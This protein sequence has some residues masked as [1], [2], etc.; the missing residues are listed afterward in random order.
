MLLLRLAA[1]GQSA[2]RGSRVSAENPDRPETNKRRNDIV[3]E[4]NGPEKNGR[5]PRVMRTGRRVFAVE[6]VGNLFARS[7]AIIAVGR[8]A[9]GKQ[10]KRVLYCYH[11][12]SLARASRRDL[13]RMT[14]SVSRS[15]AR[16]RRPQRRWRTRIVTINHAGRRIGPWPTGKD[17]KT[18]TVVCFA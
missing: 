14:M 15:G 5:E 16:S 7:Y 8:S 10:R 12:S 9:Y 17:E 11:S 18:P 2:F 13:R 3:T 6:R 1:D 4:I